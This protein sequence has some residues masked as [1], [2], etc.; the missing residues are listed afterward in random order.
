MTLVTG[1]KLGPYEILGAVGAG[2][3]GEVYRARDTR[4]ARDVA[5]KLLPQAMAKDAD[6]LRRMEQEA[7]TLAAL[8]HP[9]LL[10]IYDFGTTPEGTP[11][12]V[13]ELLRG[14]TLRA[15]ME[16][17]R[18]PVREAIALGAG[19]ARGLAAAHSRGVTHRDL[20]PENLYCGEDG[21]ITIL[22]F[23][24]ARLA[25]A[26]GAE[27]QTMAGAPATEAGMVLGT[28][29]YMSPEQARGQGAD[30]RSDIFSLG[31][32]LYE[33]F[34]GRRAFQGPSAADTLS[35][36]LREEPPEIELENTALGAP[37]SRIVRHCL[38]KLPARR[39]QS[40]DD[41]AFALE[42]VDAA[43][44]TTS[45]QALG[46]TAAPGGSR[47]RLGFAAEGTLGL[48]VVAAASW[49]WAARRARAAE[50][51]PR[52]ERLTYQL[53]SFRSAQ[54][55]NDGTEVLATGAMFGDP[56][57]RAFSA[58]LDGLGLQAMGSGIER[59]LDTA[60]GTA[61]VLQNQYKVIA[62]QTA[63]TLA[64]MPLGGGAP[65][66]L[67][68]NVEDA[69]FVPGSADA[70][71]LAIVRYHRESQR[72]SLEFPAGTVLLQNSGWYSS[73]R[74]S[75]DGSLLA[76]LEHSEAGDDAGNVVV[77]DRQG[78]V[79]LRGPHFGSTQGLAWSPD[80]KEV[81]YTASTKG[82]DRDLYALPL[83]GANRLLLTGPSSL[84]LDTV[85]GDGRALV[86][87]STDR[88]TALVVT[89]DH[90]QPRDYS[91][92]D[93]PDTSTVSAD[94]KNFLI[95]DENAGARYATYLETAAGSAPLRLGDGDPH[96]LSDDGQWALSWVPETNGKPWQLWLLPT[97]AGMQRALTHG[98]VAWLEARFV[99]GQ[100][101][102]VADGFEPG[103]ARRAYLVDWNGTM[104][105]V[106]PEGVTG[107]L[108][109]PD[110]KFVLGLNGDGAAALY[111][112]AGGAQQPLRIRFATATGQTLPTAA[113][114]ASDD[115]H[116]YVTQPT[117]DRSL[118]VL[119]LDLVSGAEQPMFTLSTTTLPGAG[120]PV[121]MG[122]SADG[123]S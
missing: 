26:S 109:T 116:L 4:L 104:R 17:G 58:R 34:S 51:P 83:S 13:C 123:K 32:V 30:A 25:V 85:L 19:I 92:L 15:R 36:I 66:P 102:I 1:T 72:S 89:G 31:A 91:V 8:T 46:A 43:H 2:G 82:I 112:L 11:Y 76:A 77:L 6:A 23:G 63:G 47:R 18:L 107:H 44:S 84:T 22:D 56:R 79:R 81:W 38:E 57:T 121:L 74:F 103:R 69:T 98:D 96:D 42:S 73:P 108:P 94:G 105:A 21:R 50:A 118:R 67:L 114:F 55:T 16:T 122:I 120:P 68:E 37:L 71:A 52:F 39:F 60:P 86:T 41:L 10:T 65:R 9:N 70:A 110:G 61:A 48:L 62:Y 64:L 27:A 12:L 7:R 101:A 106:T 75:R 100:H 5:V 54:F 99:P 45:L 24:L 90:P 97:G 113:R 95:G 117:A 87:S 115:A 49:M 20:K 40:A 53:G 14:E 29:G 78:R 33:M 93:W 35:A 80:N 3:M 111:P 28:V 59:V 88:E 119:R